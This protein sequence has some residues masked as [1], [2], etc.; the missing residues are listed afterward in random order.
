MITKEQYEEALALYSENRNIVRQ[1][2]MQQDSLRKQAKREYYKEHFCKGKKLTLLPFA[3][4]YYKHLTA[5]SK[6]VV[7]SSQEEKGAGLSTYE[8]YFKI[9]NDNGTYSTIPEACFE[10][11]QK[12]NK[13][14]RQIQ[15]PHD[16]LNSH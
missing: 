13:E 5:G 3:Q 14:Q 2:E 7:V 8:I 12:F 9:K 4:K 11:C 10:E 16:P 6:Y 1:Y 15:F